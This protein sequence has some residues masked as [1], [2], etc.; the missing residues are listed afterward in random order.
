MIYRFAQFEVDEGEFRL[1]TQGRVLAVEPKALRVLL[2]L[3]QNPNRLVR[4]QE[5]LDAVWK[6]AFVSESTLTRTIS[7]LRDQLPPHSR[8][9]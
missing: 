4:Q 7:L 2:Y 1:S 3:L 8:L 6:E 5:L 9:A